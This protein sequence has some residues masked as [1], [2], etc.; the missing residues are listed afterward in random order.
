MIGISA[1]P[2]VNSVSVEAR[3]ER[4]LIIFELTISAAE[5]LVREIQ[6]AL[7]LAEEMGRTYPER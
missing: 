2:L 5:D 4:H 6:V 7:R 3:G 1:S